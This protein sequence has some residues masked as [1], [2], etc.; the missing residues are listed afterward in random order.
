MPCGQAIVA[1]FPNPETSRKLLRGNGGLINL[2][3]YCTNISITNND[4]SWGWNRS[5]YVKFAV[6]SPG[7]G[8]GISSGSL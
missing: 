3:Y 4:M 5:G 2:P 7:G 1:R 6:R 8:S